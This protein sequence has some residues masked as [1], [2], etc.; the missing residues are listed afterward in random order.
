MLRA[1]CFHLLSIYLK[2]HSKSISRVLYSSN[3][4]CLSFIWFRHCCRNLSNLPSNIGRASL[5]T[6]VYMILQPIRRT[7]AC[8]TTNSGKLLPH[9]F[10]LIRRVADGYFLLRY[11]AITDSFPLGNMVLCVARTFLPKQYFGATNRFAASCKDNYFFLNHI[12]IT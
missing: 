1:S 7:A 8:V 11:S 12:I 4:E 10:T 6:L 9:L 5:I 2:K 3:D